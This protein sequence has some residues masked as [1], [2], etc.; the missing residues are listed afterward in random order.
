MQLVSQEISALWTSVAIVNCKY[1]TT[2]PNFNFF[3]FRLDNIENNT[4]SIFIVVT[5][6]SLM[7]ISSI[8]SDN[9]I[10]LR[11][12]FC[13]I[14]W[15]LEILNLLILHLNIFF[16]LLHSHFHSSIFYDMIRLLTWILDLYTNTI[17]NVTFAINVI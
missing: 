10:L 17:F 12:K 1:R 9:T 16:S 15:R 11:C 2:R 7:S 14:I 13:R 3:K 6:H 4:N 8:S 5:N